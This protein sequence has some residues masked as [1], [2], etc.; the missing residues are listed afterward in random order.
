MS[1]IRERAPY[2]CFV[3][4]LNRG[5]LTYQRCQRCIKA[6]FYLRTNCPGCGSVELE[7]NESRGLGTLYSSSVIFDKEQAYNVVLVDLDEGFRMM[8]TVIDCLSPTIGDRVQAHVE[9]QEGADPRVVFQ[10]IQGVSAC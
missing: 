2:E 9:A 3:E 1:D 8:S 4:G 5:V 10:R 6:V 7:L